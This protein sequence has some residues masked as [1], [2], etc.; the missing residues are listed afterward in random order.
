LSISSKVG[1]EVV[2]VLFSSA[3]ISSGCWRGDVTLFAAHRDAWAE[4]VHCLVLDREVSLVLL[5][6]G[7]ADTQ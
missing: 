2:D 5:A 3:R 6:D 4:A 1:L 7:L